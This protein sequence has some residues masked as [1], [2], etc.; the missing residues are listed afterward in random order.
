MVAIYHRSED[1]LAFVSSLHKE[2]VRAL[3][4]DLTDQE[5]VRRLLG[6]VGVNFDVCVYLAANSDPALSTQYPSLD[7]RQNVLALV[8]FLSQVRLSRLIYF[9]SG[10]VYDGISGSV[11]PA[12]P[13]SPRLPYAIDK[14]AAESYVRF[15]A[16]KAGTIGSYLNLRFF[17][18]YGPYEPKRKIYSRL[19]RSFALKRENRFIVRSDGRN[20]IDAMFVSDTISV[21][22][23]MIS[24]DVGNLTLDFC[25]GNPISINELVRRAA[26]VF[27]IKDLEIEHEGAVPEYITFWA[28]PDSVERLF[29]FRPVVDLSEGLQRLA[30]HLRKEDIQIAEHS[31]RPTS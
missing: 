14:L 8:N 13:V 11:S 7:V 1:F 2:N 30:E 28:S 17:G 6:D 4:C 19:V 24:S 10:A 31:R 23:R 20:L 27:G 21:L 15:F 18:C 25:T 12:L 26:A 29:G 3:R 5:D 16:E 22:H 9:S